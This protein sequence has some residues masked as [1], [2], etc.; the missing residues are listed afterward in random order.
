M[1]QETTY[2]GGNGL[3]MGNTEVDT[4]AGGA[5]ETP[6]AERL[7][8]GESTSKAKRTYPNARGAGITPKAKRA[9]VPQNIPQ[10]GTAQEWL[11]ILWQTRRNGQ[12]VGLKMP[13]RSIWRNGEPLIVVAI[14]NAMICGICGTWNLGN[15]CHKC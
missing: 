11:E 15:K 3:D 4:T 9:K 7:A 1:I 2:G 5:S 10:D 12:R 6:N 8:A 13:C 14:H